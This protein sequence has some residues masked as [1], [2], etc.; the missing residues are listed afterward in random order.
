[1]D[2]IFSSF[3]LRD[4]GEIKIPFSCVIRESDN[5]PGVASPMVRGKTFSEMHVFVDKNIITIASHT[6]PNLNED[7]G[8][9]YYYIE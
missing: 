1:M 9:L 4:F 2:I 7:N 3:L 6:H 5:V 8:R